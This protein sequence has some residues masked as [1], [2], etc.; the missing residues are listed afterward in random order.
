MKSTIYT[1]TL[2][3][4]FDK[5]TSVERVEPEHKLRC[6]NP[7]YQPGGGG[8][9]VSRAIKKLEGD[10]VA[11]YPIGG[12]SGKHFQSLVTSEGIEQ[13]TFQIKNWTRENFIV[14]ES[15]TN[16]QFRFGMPA[17]E[18]YKEEWEQMLS[19][20]Q[21]PANEFEYLV[22][23]GSTPK[24]VPSEFYT[25]LSQI[26]LQKKAKLVLDT[27]GD[28]LKNSLDEGIFL[29]KPNVNELSDILGEE[30]DTIEKQESA[31]MKFINSGK[32]EILV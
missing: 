20:I 16:K 3:P 4:A 27:S 30:L 13:I 31:A 7:Q 25:R 6:E 32:V 5:S 1:L 8:I 17:P 22:V 11:L 15:S 10:S 18:L 28:A 26:V 23:S 9:N 2:S 24:G 14:V 19:V 12:D 21:D 29:C